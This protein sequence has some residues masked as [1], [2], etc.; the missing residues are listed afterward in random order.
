MIKY[1]I[2]YHDNPT[3]TRMHEK[4]KMPLNTK[5]CRKFILFLTNLYI[6]DQFVS[7][8]F[9]LICIFLTD[10]YYFQPIYI[11]FSSKFGLEYLIDKS[12]FKVQTQT[13]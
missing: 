4:T 8:F 13:C 12:H 3:H 5:I 11:I 2:I 7:F 9:L 1:Y 6:F 10:L